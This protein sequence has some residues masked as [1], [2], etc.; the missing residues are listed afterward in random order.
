MHVDG[1]WCWQSKNLRTQ[2]W[3][4]ARIAQAAGVCTVP[5]TQ[6]LRGGDQPR[7][8]AA[9]NTRRRLLALLRHNDVQEIDNDRHLEER[10]RPDEAR[11]SASGQNRVRPQRGAHMTTSGSPRRA[12]RQRQRQGGPWLQDAHVAVLCHLCMSCCA[13]TASAERQTGSQVPRVQQPLAVAEC[14]SDPALIV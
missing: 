7:R 3:A 2:P 13:A 10:T 11:E 14:T 4:R 1:F 9:E 8:G 12:P 6:S 5:S